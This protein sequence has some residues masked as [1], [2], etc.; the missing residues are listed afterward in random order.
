MAKRVRMPK[1]KD[2]KVFS[3]TAVKGKKINVNYNNNARGG[4]WL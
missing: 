2:K 3:H 1:G 4:G